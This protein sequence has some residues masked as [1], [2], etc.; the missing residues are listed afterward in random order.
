M[1]VQVEGIPEALYER[2]CSAFSVRDTPMLP[3]P[4]PERS[5]DRAHEDAE[6]GGRE[7][8]VVGE[9]VTQRVGEREH[10]LADGDLREHPID[11]VRRR[12]GHAAP[13][14]GGTESPALAGE[15]DQPVEAA[16][17]AVHAHETVGEDAAAEEAPE[18]LLD[19]AGDPSLLCA[20]VR[21][22]GLEL[23]LHHA[24]EDALLWA[25][26]HVARLVSTI[27]MRMRRRRFAMPHSLA[28]LPAPYRAR[29]ASRT[30]AGVPS[31]GS[32]AAR[33]HTHC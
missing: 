21:E 8:G 13:S 29:M 27:P 25:V 33:S 16:G 6:D 19:E 24:V 11:Q 12:V 9:A 20:R 28:P 17:V 10:P 15:S 18:L 31:S 14:A 23:S 32:E 30:L 22:K 5:E 1:D 7:R 3:G 4:T 26:S 2:D